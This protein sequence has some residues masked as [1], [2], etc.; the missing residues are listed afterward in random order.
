MTAPTG[1]GKTVIF[2]L[3][4]IHLLMSLENPSV[5][6]DF[7]IVYSMLD[8]LADF[9]SVNFSFVINTLILLCSLQWPQ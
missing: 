6:D 1:S 5:R 7:K 8:M 3:A 2:E 9:N 4:I